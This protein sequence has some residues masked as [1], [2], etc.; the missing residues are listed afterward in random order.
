MMQ[1]T[2]K[3][4]S[5][6]AELW[7]QDEEREEASPG[8]GAVDPEVLALLNEEIEEDEEEIEDDGAGL[9]A[10]AKVRL[11]VEAADAVKAEDIV[12]LDVHE[13]TI[14]TD[15]FLICTGKS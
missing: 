2:K 11:M 1:K 7:S 10:E 4:G 6:P 15:Y 12:V 3:A 8:D 5:E 14:I 9:T 13:L